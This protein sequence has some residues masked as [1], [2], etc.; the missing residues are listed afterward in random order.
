MAHP[1]GFQSRNPNP[2]RD[3]KK[4]LWPRG[5]NLTSEQFFVKLPLAKGESRC[6]LSSLLSDFKHISLEF[7]PLVNLF[8]PTLQ[9][10]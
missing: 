6:I 4:L 2:K 3:I 8:H 1:S 7:A 5:G 10:S 9:N